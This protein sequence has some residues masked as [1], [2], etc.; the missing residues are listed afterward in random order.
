M[1][2]RYTIGALARAAGVKVSTLRFYERRGL[3]PAP[4]RRPGSVHAAGYRIYGAA[5]LGRL[6]FIQDAKAL[7]FSLREI[8]ELLELRVSPDAQ[9]CESV[10]EYARGKVAEIDERLHRLRTLKRG[11]I[12]MIAACGTAGPGDDCPILGALGTNGLAGAGR[13]PRPLAVGGRGEGARRA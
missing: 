11:L 12:D 3:L 5:D 9:T 13:A 4:S 6:R 8:H 10:R 1:S 7:G 2:Q